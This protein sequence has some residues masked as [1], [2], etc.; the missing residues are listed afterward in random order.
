M[1]SLTKQEWCGGVANPAKITCD[2]TTA[3][4]NT[5][6][7]LKNST[8]VGFQMTKQ[9]RVECLY[10]PKVLNDLLVHETL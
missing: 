9:S 7:D 6:T 2:V 5:Y 1:C 10:W 8:S 3:A 4:H